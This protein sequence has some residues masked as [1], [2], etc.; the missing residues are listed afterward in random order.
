MCF[1]QPSLG[2]AVMRY[3]SAAAKYKCCGRK[4]AGMREFAE[5][6][7]TSVNNASKKNIKPLEMM[8]EI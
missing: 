2:T 7:E 1:F 5:S 4:E 6:Q 8:Y 3:R